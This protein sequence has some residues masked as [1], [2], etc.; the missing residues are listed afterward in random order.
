MRDIVI[1]STW[2]RARYLQSCFNALCNVRGIQDKELWIFQNQRP[3][4]D[5]WAVYQ[6]IE[7]NLERFSHQ[8][9]FTQDFRDGT[10]EE[11][12]WGWMHAHKE[13]WQ[14][15]YESGAERVY[16]FSD[17][18]ICTPDFFEWHDAVQNAGDWFGS[19]AWRHPKGQTKP[20]DPEAYYKVTY[21]TEISMGLCVKRES[22]PAL[23]AAK[24]DWS[25]VE[26]LIVMPYVQRCYHIGG[27]SSHLKSAGENMGA[28]IDRLPDP[29]PD[30]GPQKAVLKV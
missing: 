12:N 5:W 28:A 19:S 30:Y 26:E 23:V 14:K 16:F 15:A 20:F 22:I 18:V 6:I 10:E 13:S 3:D 8:Q 24:P 1:L 17:D 25:K 27:Y 29:I 11:Q 4:A 21:P 9:F 7:E 2:Y